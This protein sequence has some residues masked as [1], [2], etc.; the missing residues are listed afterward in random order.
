MTEQKRFQLMPEE[1]VIH[2]H[3]LLALARKA[4]LPIVYSLKRS[5]VRQ[6][7][8]DNRSVYLVHPHDE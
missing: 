8:V 1:R 7:V 4:R 3:F 6:L 5:T 2:F